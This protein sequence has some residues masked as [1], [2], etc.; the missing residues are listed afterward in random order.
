MA[1]RDG[2]SV[3]RYPRELEDG[4]RILGVDSGGSVVYWDPVREVTFG[5]RV[6]PDGDLSELELRRELVMDE[7]IVDVVEE[8]GETV[9]WAELS[10]FAEGLVGESENGD[11]SS[12]DRAD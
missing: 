3:E 10:E 1:P 4:S 9:G 5:G 7:T 6:N 12:G 11:S 2:R 8:I